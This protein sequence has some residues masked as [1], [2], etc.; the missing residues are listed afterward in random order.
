MDFEDLEDLCE[1]KD[2]DT[3][4]DEFSE[5]D[6][7]KLRKA[8]AKELGITLPSKAK[9]KEKETKKKGKK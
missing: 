5:K 8:I 7:E 4:P 3:D 9:G 2:L 1:S 6:L